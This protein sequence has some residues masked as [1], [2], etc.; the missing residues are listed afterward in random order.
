MAFVGTV[1][2]PERVDR[3]Q[4]FREMSYLE[5][6]VL[7]EKESTRDRWAAI[8]PKGVIGLVAPSELRDD[9]FDRLQI[10]IKALAAC[11]VLFRSPPLFAPSQANRDRLRAFFGD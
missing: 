2:I 11:C 10:T 9:G 4:Y 3:A 8:A 7:F 6:S 5:L 1:D